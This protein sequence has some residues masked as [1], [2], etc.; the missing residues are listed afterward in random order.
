MS[1]T[2]HLLVLMSLK[3]CAEKSFSKLP[4]RFFMKVTVHTDSQTMN[5][6]SESKNNVHYGN[7]KIA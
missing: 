5:E 1:K 4:L 7:H 2:W 3:Y 6:T